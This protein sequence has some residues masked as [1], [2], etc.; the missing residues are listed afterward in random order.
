MYAIIETGGRQYKVQEGDLLRVEK[1]AGE[2]GATI[3]IGPVLAVGSG[4]TLTI[5]RPFV[6]GAKVQCTVV[7]QDRAAKILVFK[8]RR[9]KGFRKLQGHRQSYTALRV[10]AIQA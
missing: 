3:E 9:R 5:G 1:L 7:A 10:A 8:K 6:D 4:E 2:V